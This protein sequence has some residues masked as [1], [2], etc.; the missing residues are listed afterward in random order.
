MGKGRSTAKGTGA[1]GA[2][3]LLAT[4]LIWIL[5]RAHVSLSAEDGS[6]MAGGLSACALFVWHF[7]VANI[8]RQF[9]HGDS[10]EVAPA[11]Q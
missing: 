1:A 2:T 9:V 7:G 10:R 8:W 5:G 4:I 11:S 6:I 3:T